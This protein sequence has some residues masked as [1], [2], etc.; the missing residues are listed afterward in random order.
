MIELS[1]T[2]IWFIF[3]LYKFLG[4]NIYSHCSYTKAWDLKALRIKNKLE[5]LA[6]DG[7]ALRLCIIAPAPKNPQNFLACFMKDMDASKEAG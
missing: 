1:V 7:L 6:C 3:A 2:I 4:E 5:K